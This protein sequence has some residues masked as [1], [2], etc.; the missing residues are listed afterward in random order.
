MGGNS[1]ELDF[2]AGAPAVAAPQGSHVSM[3]TAALQELGYSASEIHAALKGADPSATTE[4]LV[5]F[6][7][8][9]M[10]MKG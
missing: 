3:A 2:T 1:A 6:A 4:E 7:L 9:A 8:R 5:R 10:V